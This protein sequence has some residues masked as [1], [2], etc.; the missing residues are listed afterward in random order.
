MRSIYVEYPVQMACT[1]GAAV[2]AFD[3]DLWGVCVQA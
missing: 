3:A 1:R 2:W